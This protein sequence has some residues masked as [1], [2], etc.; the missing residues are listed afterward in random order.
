V[1]R[2]ILSDILDI[3]LNKVFDLQIDYSSITKITYQKEYNK[4]TVKY[5]NRTL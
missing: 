3:P 4:Q 1:I 2:S 5:I